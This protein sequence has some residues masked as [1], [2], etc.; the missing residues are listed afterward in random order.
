[1]RYGHRDD[2][3][4]AEAEAADYDDD[5]DCRGSR[6]KLDRSSGMLADRRKKDAFESPRN[7]ETMHK[8]SK[9][10]R[11]VYYQRDPSPRYDNFEP[12]PRGS[13]SS[14]RRDHTYEDYEKAS[15]SAANNTKFN[16]D[17][18]FESDFNS[19]PAEKS[20]R[21]TTDFSDK[22][23]SRHQSHTSAPSAP[24]SAKDKTHTNE[25]GTPNQPKLR[26]DENITVSK[27]DTNADLFEDD[28]FSKVQF[29][30]EN[31]DQWIEE[32]PRKNNLKSQSAQRR[33]D[34]IKKSES[35]NIFAK[36]QDD[37]FEDDDFFKKPSPD[38]TNKK[39]TPNNGHPHSNYKWEN[40]FA[41]FDENI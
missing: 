29:E 40:S 7:I 12:M 31:E 26:F 25:S 21:F 19:T 3:Y 8:F 20:L 22:E 30:F 15:Q 35:V 39:H 2:E 18:G 41:K 38:S 23:S 32:L 6:R 34:N 17:Q 11:D 5:D 4:E 16:F 9:S 24:S 37:P 33:L 10:S 28:D 1:M 27:F 14:S 13:R 36:K